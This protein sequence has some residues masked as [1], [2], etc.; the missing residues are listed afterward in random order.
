MYVLW[1]TKNTLAVT[2]E[3]VSCP[4]D[5]RIHTHAHRYTRLHTEYTDEDHARVSFTYATQNPSLTYF[6]SSF[7]LFLFPVTCELAANYKNEL[8]S[9][10]HTWH[11]RRIRTQKHRAFLGFHV[12]IVFVDHSVPEKRGSVKLFSID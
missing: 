4:F 12:S 5:T 8:Q 1:K 2:T 10:I 11:T 7:F 3:F 9:D 6:C